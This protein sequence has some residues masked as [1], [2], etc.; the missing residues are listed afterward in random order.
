MENTF[1]YAQVKI[2]ATKLPGVLR[3][4]PFAVVYTGNVE[5]WSEVGTT[6]TR[7]NEWNPH[8]ATAVTLPADNSSQQ[9]VQ[10]RV[11]FYNKQRADSRFLGTA[12]LHLSAVMATEGETELALETPNAKSKSRVFIRVLQGYNPLSGDGGGIFSCAFQLAQTN[13]WGVS[14]RVFYEISAA[15]DGT[16]APV[17]KSDMAKLDRQGWGQFDTADMKLRDLCRDELG[18]HLLFTLYR[19]KRLGHKRVLG[20]FQT[21]V[22]AL[23]RMQ[24][25]AFIDFLPNTAEDIL[26]A[27]II[28]MHT[29]KQTGKYSVGLKLVNVRWNAPE[30]QER[31]A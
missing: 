22:Q 11:D 28:V 3:C 7:M 12:S 29:R 2:R 6:E 19:H 10:L 8:F 15:V 26:S 20:T 16:W 17:Y 5:S 18:T 21:S 27:D 1:R 13:H 25:G 14:M 31:Q 23:S 30:V 4:D 9:G 24:Q